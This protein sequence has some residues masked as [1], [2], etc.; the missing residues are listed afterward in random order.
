MEY[1]NPQSI[2]LTIIFLKKKNVELHYTSHTEG[3]TKSETN[4]IT[5]SC[6]TV[7]TISLM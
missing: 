6:E 5:D 4:V 1:T 3:L 2:C 7:Y